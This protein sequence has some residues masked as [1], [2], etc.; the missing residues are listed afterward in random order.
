MTISNAAFLQR[1]KTSFSLE[2][3]VNETEVV[4]LLT[5]ITEGAY[6]IRIA[7]TISE[8]I[9]PTRESTKA[10]LY[11]QFALNGNS[12]LNN[13]QLVRDMRR[14][15]EES[16]FTP[17]R[18][19]MWSLNFD[20]IDLH[21]LL[22]L[23]GYSTADGPLQIKL[24]ELLEAGAW[25]IH[26]QNQILLVILKPTL[27]KQDESGRLH[28][29]T[30]PALNL[31]DQ[32]WYFWHGIGISPE[33]VEHPETI[34]LD[35]IREERN[36][37]IKRIL[38][39]RYGQGRYLNDVY[40]VLIDGVFFN[41]REYQLYSYHQTGDETL[42]MLKVTNATPE[43]DGT[44]KDYWI[45]TPPNIYKAIKALAWTFGLTEE[46]YKTLSFES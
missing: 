41:G 32:M 1:Y 24:L 23:L 9:N 5:E 28:C 44:F 40:S 38:I 30:G 31:L 17:V 46:Q 6:E 7:R 8:C 4:R 2:S 37:E 15:W 33:I 26:A 12:G 3:P 20:S 39:D 22:H 35:L 43:P 29:A 18:N 21:Y 42:T 19:I 13:I 11:R 45:R 14:V 34:T 16:S 27:L 36:I 10:H 25:N